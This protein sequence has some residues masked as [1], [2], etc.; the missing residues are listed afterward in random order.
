MKFE[1]SECKLFFFC[2]KT[3]RENDFATKF[4]MNLFEQVRSSSFLTSEDD[5][6][7]VD[8]VVR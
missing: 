5:E 7:A 8:V 6:V 2:C 1:N 4:R 3:K